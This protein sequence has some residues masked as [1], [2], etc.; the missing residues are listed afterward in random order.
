[1]AG[2][3]PDVAPSA[4]R[5]G[6]PARD[7]VR[8]PS[9]APPTAS[10]ARPATSGSPATTP[11]GCPP[12]PISRGVPTLR[13][14][15][16]GRL[17]PLLL[18]ARSRHPSWGP[19]KLLR[20]ADAGSSPRRPGRRDRTSP[21]ISSAPGSSLPPRR[22]RRPGHTGRPQA[23]MDAPN[24]VWTTDFKGQ[25]RL[26]DGTLCYPL[27]IADGYSRCCSAVG[28]SQHASRREPPRLRA[29]LSGL[30]LA[31]A[32]SL[33]Q[34]RPVRHP[35]PRP[36]LGALGLVASPR[37]PARSLEPALTPAKRPPRT[38]APH[39]Q[40]RVYAARPAHSRR[41]SNTAS[42]TGATNTT[43]CA[44]TRRSTMRPRPPS[45]RPRHDPIPAAFPRSS[46][47][48]I[49]R[50]AASATTAASAGTSSGST[51]VRHSVGE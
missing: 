51:S 16:R 3:V 49:T 15:P 2:G 13:R 38:D 6:R 12:S 7:H 17:G 23:P 9:S 14:P 41:R 20:L 28:R 32:H 39:P 34:R 33:R 21:A 19:R 27:T 29:R 42:T 47:P 31:G 46:I 45:T 48:A 1:M 30:G 35:G 44:R 5:P 26:G 40:T 37:H 24:A 43:S 50:S 8:S 4:V 11:V 36:P 10:A 22:V 18:A 25:F